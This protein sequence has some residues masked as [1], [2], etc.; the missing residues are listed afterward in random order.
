MSSTDVVEPNW[1]FAR[2]L[3]FLVWGV[4]GLALFIAM[5]VSVAIAPSA[6]AAGGCGGG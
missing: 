2:S 4:L 5:F 6:N 3:V 1:S